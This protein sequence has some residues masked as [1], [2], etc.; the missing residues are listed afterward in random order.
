MKCAPQA[1]LF[2][3]SHSHLTDYVQ[4][5]PDAG[6]LLRM[7]GSKVG[8]IAMFGIPLQQQW[9]Y[10]IS[11]D[12]APTYYLQTTR[13]STTTR[14]PTPH[15]DGLPVAAAGAAGAL[16]SD[17]HRLQ[18]G[19]HVRGRHVRRVLKTF[20][21][22][23]AGIGE[24]TIHK[25]FVPSKVAGARRACRPGPGPAARFAAEVGLVVPHPQRHRRALP[26]ANE[27]RV[28]RAD[29][30]RVPAPPADHGHLG[31]HSAS[32]A[33]SR[34][35]RATALVSR[36]LDDPELSHVNFDI[37]WNEGRST[38]SRADMPR[39]RRIAGV[40]NRQPRPLPVRH[41]RGRR[42]RGKEY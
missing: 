36:M 27:P 35:S 8:R 7:V 26:E 19:G 38:S 32:G 1:A 39:D 2:N 14:S 11:G 6:Q 15:R 22:V 13:R 9:S 40:M 33:S 16:R 41:R 12:S 5:G 3:D 20:P 25:E 28:P 4:R 24:F 34:P 37:S 31:P 23:F 18:P 30:R 42:R 10:R 17:D 29:A 21:G